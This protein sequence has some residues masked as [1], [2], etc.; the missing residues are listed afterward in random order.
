MRTVGGWK[1]ERRTDDTRVLGVSSLKIRCCIREML[2]RTYLKPL[3]NMPCRVNG[4]P[5]T[6]VARVLDDTPLVGI[7]AGER[8]LRHRRPRAERE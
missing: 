2:A 1:N 8:L 3:G 5:V 7:G 6:L 4:E